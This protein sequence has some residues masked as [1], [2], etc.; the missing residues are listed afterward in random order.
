MDD[1]KRLVYY[2]ADITRYDGSD[3]SPEGED[4]PPGEGY[5]I[6]SG[7]YDPSRAPGR[8]IDNR[9]AVSPYRYDPSDLEIDP[10]EFG[11]TPAGWLAGQ[12]RTYLEGLAEPDGNTPTRT[13][14]SS[15]A[16]EHPYEAYSVR[17]AAHPEGFTPEEIER[18]VRLANHRDEYYAA[19]RA[20]YVAGACDECGE[21]VGP[22]RRAS[23]S[24]VHAT[25]CSLHP[26]NVV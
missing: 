9:E 4:V 12:L 8:V 24:A 7:W 17:P 22:D 26:N 23:V 15:Q 10:G 19:A 11:Y 14:Y 20:H 6:E 1:K 3:T 21:Y 13:I 16:Y 5:K 18:A 2:T 25:D